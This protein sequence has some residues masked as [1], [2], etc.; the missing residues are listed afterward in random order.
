[1]PLDIDAVDYLSREQG[2]DPAFI[3]KDWHA[4]RVLAALCPYSKGEIAAVFTGG[5]SLSKAHGLLKRFSEDLDF[6]INIDPSLEL[7]NAQKDKRLSSFREAVL[8]ALKSIDD[9]VLDEGSTFINGLGFKVQLTYPKVFETP[10]GMR[11]ELQVE[12]SKTPSRLSTSDYPLTSFIA[13]YK[14]LPPETNF[15]CVSP[16][17][18][19][20]DKF[21]SL[22]WR[23]LKRD[24][25]SKDDDP[26]MIRHLHDLYA[27]K[28]VIEQNAYLVKATL[29]DAFNADQC[30]AKR[31]IDMAL[32]VAAG[33]VHKIMKDD[34]LYR[35]EY[36]NFV[37]AMSYADDGEAVTFEDALA[38]FY[39]L[40]TSVCASLEV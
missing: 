9:I 38:Y 28:P 5:T 36:Q 35:D 37:N 14:G 10:S 40:R 19:A 17:E 31:K 22:V 18:I 33:E 27:L 39:L 4:V 13:A 12:F 11:P 3:E 23:V 29:Y 6:R 30:I 26:A 24:R 2:I 34:P 25:S 32:D 7:S 16:V 1:M 8:N 20:A 21:S 15:Q